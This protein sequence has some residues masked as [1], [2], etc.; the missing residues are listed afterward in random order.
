MK[1]CLLNVLHDV[2][3]KRMYH[4][5]ARSLVAAGHEV[6]SIAPGREKAD[7]SPEGIRWMPVPGAFIRGTP[8]GG[9]TAGAGPPGT[10]GCLYRAG[11]GITVAALT[12]K[13]LPAARRYSTCMNTF[14]VNS[15]FFPAFL[16]GVISR[17][18]VG[19]MRLSPA[20]R[21]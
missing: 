20:T 6:V 11:T 2:L 1:I 21:T 16:R 8:R 3:D 7:G 15:Q 17:I 13:G 9:S 19:F 12:I 5:I 18:T 14:R 4:K 10:G